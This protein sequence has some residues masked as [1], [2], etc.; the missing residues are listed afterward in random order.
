MRPI[1]KNIQLVFQDPYSSLNPRMKVKEIIEEGLK[2]HKL[3]ESKDEI[4]NSII[5][6]LEKVGLSENDLDKYPK[7]FSGGQRQRIAIAR[8]LAVKPKFIICDEPVSALDMSIQAQIINLLVQLK[9]EN[10]LSILFISHDLSVVN[11]FCERVYVM[12]KGRIIEDG[13]CKEIF[14]N[15]KEAYTKELF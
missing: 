4:Q 10:N 3:F 8:A 6:V 7:D 15:P 2:I 14:K 11:F 12:Q 5:S 9:N 13:T 1:R